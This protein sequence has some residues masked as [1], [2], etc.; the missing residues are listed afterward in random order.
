MRRKTV[1]GDEISLRTTHEDAQVRDRENCGTRGLIGRIL[2]KE[3][4]CV[5][6]QI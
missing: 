3:A 5:E 6:I 4:A 2:E 1:P